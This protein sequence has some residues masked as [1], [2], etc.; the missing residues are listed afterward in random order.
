MSTCHVPGIKLGAEAS[1][2]EY[3][4]LLVPVLAKT[5]VQLCD[6]RHVTYL[7][8][9]YFRSSSEKRNNKMY[10]AGLLGFLCQKGKS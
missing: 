3:D 1:N 2:N 10:F 6:L 8:E 7:S 5:A 4:R 9:P